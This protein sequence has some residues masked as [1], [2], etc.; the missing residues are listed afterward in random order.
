M[1]YTVYFSGS[2]QVEA[3]SAE[4]AWMLTDTSDADLNLDE[5]VCEDD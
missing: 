2:V 5:V 1:L 3:D 4:E